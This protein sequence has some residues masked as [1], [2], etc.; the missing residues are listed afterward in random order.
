MTRRELRENIFKL[1]FI[2]EFHHEDEYFDQE[3]LYFEELGPVEEKD[4]LY[5]KN[6]LSMILEKIPEIDEKLEEKS[7]GWS[8]SRMG[9]AEK[10]IL[11]LAYYELKFDEDIPDKVAINEAIELAKEFGQE[12]GASF[13]NGVLAKLV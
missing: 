5:I 11:R 6:K 1:L 7:Q 4:E 3:A 2:L 12:D 10:N 9:S 8:L 13:V